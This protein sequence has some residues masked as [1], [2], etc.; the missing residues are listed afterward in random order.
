MRVV[1]NW[2]LSCI[3]VTARTLWNSCWLVEFNPCPGDGSLVPIGACRGET[4]SRR[5]AVVKLGPHAKV[6]RTTGRVQ[7]ERRV[8]GGHASGQDHVWEEQRLGRRDAAGAEGEHAP[9]ERGGE[10]APAEEQQPFLLAAFV[11]VW[12]S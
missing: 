8:R 12:F 9:P 1:L 7:S 4:K 5:N 10:G 3:I 11:V 6:G 2:S